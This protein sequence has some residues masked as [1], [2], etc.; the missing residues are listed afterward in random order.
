MNTLRL[1]HCSLALALSLVTA[2]QPALACGD[3]YGGARGPSLTQRR[4]NA[5]MAVVSSYVQAISQRNASHAA[6]AW[7]ASARAHF[8]YN[9]CCQPP[10]W[11]GAEWVTQRL[12]DR[13]YRIVSVTPVSAT[14]DG[15]TIEATSEG[16]QGRWS[17]TITVRFEDDAWRIAS[18][19]ARNSTSRAK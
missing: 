10:T 14:D 5:A 15:V 8:E 6:S 3:F 2:A 9:G 4:T 7:H 16:A 11:S 13:R 18:L 12:A 1:A 19:F 17:E